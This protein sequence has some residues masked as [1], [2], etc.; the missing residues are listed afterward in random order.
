MN[1]TD[2]FALVVKLTDANIALQQEVAQLRSNA[3]AAEFVN[4][5]NDLKAELHDLRA[6]VLELEKKEVI[7]LAGLFSGKTPVNPN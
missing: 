1:T 5:I 4:L 6:A 7:K 3:P 2:L